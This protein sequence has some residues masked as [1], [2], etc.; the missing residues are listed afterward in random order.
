MERVIA[1]VFGMFVLLNEII[2]RFSLDIGAF[3]YVIMMSVGLIML[4][5][6][7]VLTDSARMVVVFLSV[8]LVRVAGLFMDVSYA[9]KVFLGYGILLFLGV[10]YLHKFNIDIGKFGSF[11][12]LPVVACFGFVVGIV[13]NVSF[14]VQKEL[15][16]IMLLPLI[17]FSEEIFFRAL[18]QNV[19]EKSCGSFY[20]VV[21]PAFI[22]GALSLYLGIGLAVLF[23]F[24]SLFSGLVYLSSRNIF[25]TIVFNLIVS[26]FVFVVPSLI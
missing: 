12:M 24:V 22:Y 14:V 4:S 5:R 6:E 17:V 13:G 1:F 16:L 20:S 9:W 10:Y 11:W 19:V 25:L 18:M 23:F 2:L 21:V 26:V 7:E 15:V 8:P 3:M